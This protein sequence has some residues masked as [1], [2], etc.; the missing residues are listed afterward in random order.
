MNEI[1]FSNFSQFVFAPYFGFA[2]FVFFKC[3]FIVRDPLECIV[4]LCVCVVL[5]TMN[6][7]FS[8]V[9]FYWLL[10]IWLECTNC[11]VFS[12][13]IFVFEFM[14]LTD[15]SHARGMGKKKIRNST[16]GLGV[17]PKHRVH[18]YKCLDQVYEGMRRKKKHTNT[19]WK[20]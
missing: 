2:G 19:H 5:H 20:K 9:S 16:F 10:A 3:V 12:F 4:V 18:K 8:C 15:F 11:I 13:V 14:E 17:R 7:Y 1:I 6:G